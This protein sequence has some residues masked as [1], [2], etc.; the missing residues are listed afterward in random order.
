MTPNELLR[1][2]YRLY[3]TYPGCPYYEGCILI[4]QSL[5]ATN[6]PY[7]EDGMYGQP[8]AQAMYNPEKYPNNFS[9]LK[10]WENRAITDWPEYLRDMQGDVYSVEIGIIEDKPHLLIK[11]VENKPVYRGF[12]YLTP[13]TKQEYSEYKGKY[14]TNKAA[15]AEGFINQNDIK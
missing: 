2:R 5:G 12:V 13:A 11:D 1:P 15:I 6:S 7:Y 3:A 9:K 14:Y 10:W 8:N 4:Q